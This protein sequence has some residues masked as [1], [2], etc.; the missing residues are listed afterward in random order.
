MSRRYSGGLL[1]STKASASSEAA[2]GIWS[3]FSVFAQ[4]SK[5]D[6]PGAGGGGEP[7]SLIELLVVAGGGAGDYGGGGGR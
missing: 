5:G 7:P 1:S 3:L 2:S 6:W 4:R